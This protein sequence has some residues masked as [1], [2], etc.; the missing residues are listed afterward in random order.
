MR[1]TI[2]AALFSLLIFPGSGHFILG[3][4]MRGLVFFLPSL[5]SAYL[6]VKDAIAQANAL[7]GQLL[8]G[9][10]P[11]NLKTSN[12]ELATWLFTACWLASVADSLYLGR[13]ADRIAKESKN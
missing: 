5:I 8:E 12:L 4:Y 10:V 2:K 13:K 1:N 6:L 11:Q 7:A 3:K 9:N